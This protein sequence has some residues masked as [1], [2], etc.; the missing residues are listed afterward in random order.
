MQDAQ[1]N[2]KSTDAQLRAK[3]KYANSKYRPNVYID[4]DKR[5]SIEKHFSSKGY[6]SFNEYVCALVDE[7]MKS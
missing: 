3:K 4:M 7:D 2:I 1:R 5:E 6:K